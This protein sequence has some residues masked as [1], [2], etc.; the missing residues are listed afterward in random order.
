MKEFIVKRRKNYVKFTCRIEEKMLEKIEIENYL[1]IREKQQLKVSNTITT[2]IGENASGKTAILKAI[3]KLN[4]R[5][6]N[7]VAK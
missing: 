6:R 2:L 4:R 7:S 1:S 3:D 5:K